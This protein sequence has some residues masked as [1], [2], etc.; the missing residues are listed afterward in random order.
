MLLGRI[1]V[2]FN[3]LTNIKFIKYFHGKFVKKLFLE[4]IVFLPPSNFYLLSLR[5]FKSLLTL[6]KRKQIY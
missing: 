3:D 1:I 4:Q 2:M 6:I 5:F